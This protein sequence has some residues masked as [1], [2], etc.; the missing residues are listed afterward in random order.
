MVH[1]HLSHAFPISYVVD[2]LLNRALLERVTGRALENSPSA[3]QSVF[4]LLFP[5][6]INLLMHRH[7]RATRNIPQE[8]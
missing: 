4:I 2:R 8:L 1:R 3:S 7:V 6:V 5:Q